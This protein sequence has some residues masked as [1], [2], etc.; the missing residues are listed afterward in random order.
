MAKQHVTRGLYCTAWEFRKCTKTSEIFKF[1]LSMVHFSLRWDLMGE[2][3]KECIK[4]D[5]GYYGLENIIKIHS[6]A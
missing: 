3:L 5:Y 2:V 4:T 6:C 1:V